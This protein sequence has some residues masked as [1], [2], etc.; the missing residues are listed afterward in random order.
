MKK[1]VMFAVLFLT[2][3]VLLSLYA[4]LN[5]SF[6]L[7][8][9]DGS[10]AAPIGEEAAE[11]TAEEEHVSVA[12]LIACAARLHADYH[13]GTAHFTEESPWYQVC[14]EYALA[15]GIIPEGEFT[16]LDRSATRRELAGIRAHAYPAEALPAINT[17]VI[18]AIPDVTVTDT[19]WE[20]IY[21]MYR[22][23]IICACDDAGSFRPD[24]LITRRELDAITLRMEDE[25]AR[26]SI[27][28]GEAADQPDS[29]RHSMERGLEVIYACYSTYYNDYQ[30]VPLVTGLPKLT[31]EEIDWLI[32]R[33]DPKLT[34]EAITT[35]A[36]CG[37]YFTRAQFMDYDSNLG[38]GDWFTHLCGEQVVARR[39]GFCGAMC[40]ALA[41]LLRGDYELYF[42]LIDGH[43]MMSMKMDGF[44]YLI[45]P[46]TFLCNPNYEWTT[47]HFRGYFEGVPVYAD[48]LQTIADSMLQRG[49]TKTFHTYCA[50]HDMLP[51]ALLPTERG[52]DW[53]YPSGS[54]VTCWTPDTSSVSYRD[55]S[56]DY[57]YNWQ[58][59]C[60]MSES[61]V[62]PVV[63]IPS[64]PLPDYPGMF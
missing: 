43:V 63:G 44:Y 32:E 29:F 58:T 49:H 64:L 5:S 6:P 40:N 36:D 61:F 21:A 48:D 62:T 14:V 42:V 39:G 8:S 16:Q 1:S 53:V 26:L 25:S 30:A 13:G 55:V 23:G 47:G 56:P 28:L 59:D 33:G 24:E 38:I 2:V 50:T 54:E 18:S 11:T 27:S 31:N 35:L 46:V 37:N 10:Q 41:Y 12:E 9:A 57:P 4:F 34:A 3:A 17:V 20:E 19:Y 22:A 7:V 52:T 51:Q 45:D 15:N 60:W